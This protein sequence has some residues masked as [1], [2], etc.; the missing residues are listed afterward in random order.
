METKDF[1]LHHA[2]TNEDF[3]VISY[4]SSGRPVIV[5]PEADSSCTSWEYNG[6]IDVL[7][8]IL[9]DGS[10]RLFC[11][12]SAD[13]SSWYAQYAPEGY[14]LESVSAYFD[15]VE[16]ELADFIAEEC[17]EKDGL[18]ILAGAGVGALNATIEMLRQPKRYA[19]LLALSGT[20]DARRYVGDGMSEE[21]LAF[22][23][24][25]LAA[26]LTRNAA[27]AHVFEGRHLAFICGQGDGEA[28]ID[29]Q[30]ALDASLSQAGVEATFEYWGYDVT[31]GWGWWKE[32]ARQLLPCLLTPAGLAE[33]G[34]AGEVD[35][36]RRASKQADDEL[37]ASN[38]ELEN[39]RGALEDA[40]KEK[41]AT[42]E[43]AEREER[44]VAD[45]AA[46]AERLAAAAKQA[47]AERDKIAEQLAEAERRA[48][49]AQA[50]ADGAE[51][52]RSKA[53]WIAGE[54][55]AA[56]DAAAAALEAATTRLADAETLEKAK[57]EAAKAASEGLKSTLAR[58]DEVR[59]AAVA[60]AEKASVRVATAKMKP[61]AKKPASTTTKKTAS[62]TAKKPSSSTAKKP[63]AKKASTSAKKP[64]KKSSGTDRL[65]GTDDVKKS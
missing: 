9:E 19:G 16:G 53:A 41:D 8:G 17:D 61:A 36:A 33:R 65:A 22:S 46:V 50:E 6:M 29:T 59:A 40:R 12:D 43:R 21:W 63:A 20:Y 44:V 57:T 34:M 58:L 55:T 49:D 11:V 56:R 51:N 7:S 4:G 13:R 38:T 28:G 45:R 35:A 24:V 47:W 25:D 10:A 30:R 26:E 39:A 2:E 5:F 3:D 14:R 64:A 37:V 31:Y 1:T 18:P 48:R 27:A 23:P 62:S 60:A 52:E 15:F 42:R 32:E 54:A